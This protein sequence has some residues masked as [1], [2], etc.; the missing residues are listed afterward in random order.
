MTRTIVNSWLSYAP[1]AADEDTAT[2]YI[3]DQIGKDWWENSG[4]SANDFANTLQALSGTK[5]LVIEINSPGGN[6]WDGLAIY[7]M[8][9]G[10]AG[11]VTTRVVG[12]AASIASI[13]AL[14]GKRVE[15]AEAALYMVHDPSGMAAGTAE[16]MRKMADALDQH[17]EVLGG[18]YA[19]KTGQPLAK[20]R[21]LMRAETWFTGP[22]AVADGF[23]DAVIPMPAAATASFDFSRFRKSPANVGTKPAPAQ[24]T[25]KSDTMNREKIVALLKKRGVA[26]PDNSTDEQVIALLESSEPTQTATPPPAPAAET[27]SND[28]LASVLARLDAINAKLEARP[29]A[30]VKPGAN[31]GVEPVP[32][33]A[34]TADQKTVSRAEFNAMSAVDQSSF[35]RTGGRITD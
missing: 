19:R 25:N 6:V 9:R 26:V 31:P 21:D 29:A 23:V 18:V 14:A 16:D 27:A 4:V 34:K 1:R 7:N 15:I 3:F 8:L 12:V 5:N 33:A 35:C 10:W 2:I 20:M 17:A 30:A 32:P 11:S 28:V 13:I 24:K 22:Q